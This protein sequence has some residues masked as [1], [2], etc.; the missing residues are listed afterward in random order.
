M[1]TKKLLSVLLAALMIF[2]L[3]FVAFGSEDVEDISALEGYVAVKRADKD[4]LNDGDYY[5]TFDDFIIAFYYGVLAP[6]EFGSVDVPPY[7]ELDDST[8]AEVDDITS[9]Y[10]DDPDFLLYNPTN[11][12]ICLSLAEV[13]AETGVRRGSVITAHETDDAVTYGEFSR[14]IKTYETPTQPA[15]PDEPTPDEPTTDEPADKPT[16][17]NKG[18]FDYISKLFDWLIE[19]VQMF[20]RWISK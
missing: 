5:M 1:K 12:N 9:F 8:R 20:T 6:L 10:Y 15:Q 3:T 13:D 4:T 16:D 18:G 14:I 19:L 11:G 7:E 2:S 17:N